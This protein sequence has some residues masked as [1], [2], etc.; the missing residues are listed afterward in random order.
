MKNELQLLTLVA[1]GCENDD[2]VPCELRQQVYHVS[3]LVLRRDE[4][5]VLNELVDGLV[6]GVD[7]DLDWVSQTCS[8]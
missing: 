2:L 5:V 3:F 1:G 8:L 7:L 4:D 6:L